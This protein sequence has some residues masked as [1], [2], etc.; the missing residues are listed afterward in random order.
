MDQSNINSDPSILLL[1]EVEILLAQTRLMELYLKQAQASAANET[2]RV[3]QQHQVELATLRAALAAQ[4]NIPPIV[5]PDPELIQKVETIEAELDAN[6]LLL[7]QRDHDLAATQAD[8]A[9]LR[10]EIADLEL[11]RQ[12]SQAAALESV[13]A[14]KSLQAELATLRRELEAKRH[15]FAEQQR[16]AWEI[17]HALRRQLTQLQSDLNDKES[18]SQN[19]ANELAQSRNDIAALRERVA[20][21]ELRRQQAQNNAAVELEQTRSRFEAETGELRTALA[22]RA[23]AE[24]Q[25][26][27]GLAQVEENLQSKI[28]ALKDQLEQ[29][30]QQLEN[31][32]AEWR[33]AQSD[34]AAANRRVGDLD[35]ANRQAAADAAAFER[36][37]QSYET[38]RAEL[39]HEIAVKERELTQ[40]YE[41]VTAVELALHGKIQV[42]QQELARSHDERASQGSELD[43]AR[44]EIAQLTARIG[45]IDSAREQA[46]SA[47]MRVAEE[48]R[49][50]LE[51]ELDRLHAVLAQKEFALKERE[52]GYK[53]L[54]DRLTEETQQLRSQLEEQQKSFAAAHAELTLAQAKIAALQEESGARDRERQRAEEN[55]QRSGIIQ[56]EL[57]ERLQAR[58]QELQAAK[59]AADQLKDEFHNQRNELQLELARK[60]L[61][62]DSRGAEVGDLRDS[63]GQLAEQLAQAE[64]AQRD[65]AA[66]LRQAEQSQAPQQNQLAALNEAHRERYQAL[67]TRLEQERTNADELRRQVQVLERQA[68]QRETEFNEKNQRLDN[69]KVETSSLQSRL[70][71]LESQLAQERASTNQLRLQIQEVERSASERERALDEKSASLDSIRAQAS[72]DQARLHELESQLEKHQADAGESEQARSALASEIDSLRQELQRKSWALAQQQAS[73]ENLALAH[74]EQIHKLEGQLNEQRSSATAQA[75]ELDHVHVQAAALR[76]RIEELETA[77][78]HAEVAA[79]SRAEQL[80]EE[81]AARDQESTTALPQNSPD[82][83]QRS[84]AQTRLEQSLHA[85]IDR[86]VREV[87]ERNQILQNRNDELVRVKAEMDSIHER[88]AQL[89]LS[90]S[91]SEAA[92]QNESEHMRTEFQA[93][94]ALLQAELSQKEWALEERHAV[95]SGT[96]QELRLEIDALRRQQAKLGER[97]TGAFVIGDRE[98]NRSQREHAANLRE[99]SAGADTGGSNSTS[100]SQ[101]R[102]WRTGF[103]WKRRWKG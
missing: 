77:L 83:E 79:L 55:W 9:R 23:E 5:V 16:D 88:F 32:D 85:E 44:E 15:E 70:A 51:D 35:E 71:A 56:K 47:G 89:E 41:A 25:S 81:R 53:A 11:S 13:T 26:R 80:L 90:T 84:A 19:A 68:N 31:R 94:L 28:L 61:L 7:N 57:Q 46:E 21:L 98:L 59:T 103:A 97:D 60:Q 27:A 54:E 49:Q 72:A 78:S 76:R 14:R 67:E 39:H 66:R 4:E 45:E 22:A 10:G 38:D 17:E 48:T 20:E 95:A 34:L 73:V 92:A 12:Q 3:D 50:R 30:Q 87:Q 62:A 42:L 75:G 100:D 82:V 36:A 74:K 58:S 93:Q 65:S 52:N 1:N 33:Q 43:K 24:Q 86:L 29:K 69:A 6:R 37:K 8:A 40:R 63:L 99:I 91:Q 2:L 96:E 101:Q 18:W 64:L 102:R